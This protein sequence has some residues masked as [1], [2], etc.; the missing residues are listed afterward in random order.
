MPFTKA[1]IPYGAY[2]SSPY[3]KW[4]GSFANLHALQL[5]ATTAR[6]FF[7]LKKI[8]VGRLDN[9]YLGMTIPQ[10][11]CFYGGPWTMAMLGGEK[12]TAPVLNQACI[13]GIV[14]TKLAAADMELGL[15]SASL[16]ITAD[17]C[18]NGPHLY[19][20]S[21]VA[22]GA[23]G[24][25]EDW[26]LDNFGHDPWAKNAM[27]QTAENVAKE[28]GVTRQ[29]NDEV[30][31]RRYEQYQDALKD[32]AAFLKKFMVPVD[33]GKGKKQKTI[34]IDEGVFPST[35]DGLKKLEPVLPGGT[36]TFGAQTHPADGNTGLIVAT[37]EVAAELSADPKIEIQILGF[38]TARER[39]GYMAA[40]TLPATRNT[41]ADAGLKI[42]DIKVIKTHNPFATNDV[43]LCKE[44]GLDPMDVNNYGSSII[45]GHPQ[46]PTAL[47]TVIELIEELVLKGGGYGLYAGCAAG[48]TAG[49]LI[50]KVSS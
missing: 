44:F 31:A 18:S 28:H 23:T 14:C 37:K 49:G 2:W 15:A 6:K 39:K 40:A 19:Y 20:P 36:I 3:S 27:I 16:A 48:D 10:T 43:V 47:R 33:V 5:A 30:A 26:V 38:G 45:W 17:R 21:Q 25:S 50:I 34:A 42:E 35:L 24:K 8:D 9:G 4:Q 29:Q 13:T 32:D 11:S 46:G 41:L 1:F 22:P 7:E 12:I